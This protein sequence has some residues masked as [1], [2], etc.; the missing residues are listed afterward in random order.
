MRARWV[1]PLSGLLLVL[2]P[3]VSF[4][5]HIVGGE[6]YYECLGNNTYRITLK[7]Y[8]DCYSFGQ[9][10]AWFDNP[11][12][13][14]IYTADGNL[15]SEQQVYLTLGPDTIPPETRNPCLQAP[16]NVC[17]EE[18]VYEF[19]I[20]LPPASGG[21]DIVYVR[22]C[23]NATVQN[24]FTPNAVGATYSAHIP[25]PGVASCNSSPYFSDFPPI[26]ICANAPINF[27]HSA[28]D[29]DGDSLVYSLCTP[30]DGADS[31]TPQPYPADIL[32]PFG[33]VIWRS[34]YSAANPLDASP[35]VTLD[36]RTGF[37]TGTPTRLGQYVVGVCVREY[38]NGV[39]IG[40]TKRDFQF[41]VVQCGT[42]VQARIP[43]VDT[44]GAAATNTAGV[45]IYQCQGLFVQFINH[46]INGTYYRW[47][48]GD[49]TTNADT[50]LLFQPAYTYPDS[51][52]YIVRL[53]VNPG[54]FCADTTAVIVKIYPTFQADFDF[55]AGCA[56]LPVTFSD[57]SITTYGTIN[58]WSWNFGDG[59]ASTTQHP[60]HL[61][62]QDG[63]FAVTLFAT[64]TKGCS[65]SQ[66]KTV[67]VH[68]MPQGDFSFTPVCINTPVTFTDL[69]TISSGT[70]SSRSWLFNNNP[71][72]SSATFTQTFTNLMTFDL[73]LISSSAFGCTD[74][75]TK[76]ITVH[77]LPVAVARE[78]TS[79]CVGESV[80]L[81]ASGG[82]A[83][84]WQPA[85]GLSSATVANPLATP[86]IST[87]Y[88]VTVTDTN[89]CVDK[90][91]VNIT[92]N[93]L[94]E[95]YAGEDTYICEGSMLQLNGSGGISFLWSPGNLVS[96]S[97]LPNPTT[98]P[99]DTT[100]FVLTTYNI[101]G[102][103]NYDSL[104]IA[105]QHPI[106]LSVSPA[107]D[108]C[109]GNSV[110][111]SAAGGLYYTW[112]PAGGL[113]GIHSSDYT[114]T[115]EVSTR[116]SV[117]VSNDC[118]SDTGYVD[119]TVRPLPDVD[120]GKDTS[121]VRD[122]FVTLSGRA[123]GITHFWTPPEGLENPNSLTTLASPF[124]TTDYVL[125]AIS[126]YNC[127]ATDTMRV[128]VTVVNLIAIPT[129]FSPNS[130]GTNDIYR[131]VKTLNIERLFFFKIYNRWGQCIFETNDIR[132][133]WDGTVYGEPQDIGV[134]AFI[135]KAFN[136][137]GE[138]II[139]EGNVTLVR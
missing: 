45:F 42:N 50:S 71:F 37:L 75:V 72:D 104:T 35:A 21:Y 56:N 110:T 38:R 132:Q 47:D 19:T 112:S 54:Y 101:F 107:Q 103:R 139:K 40:E 100:T 9:N 41:N 29:A 128:S 77:P 87:L 63:N 61:Y 62:Q 123:T 130:D 98:S 134:Y 64:N 136:R 81:M 20:Y 68:P 96:D 53:I 24:I 79:L 6:M 82:T 59:I 4:A 86:A 58:S 65:D 114:I 119:V 22:C 91:S 51:G 49:P 116:Y 66:T 28:V 12:Y 25:D 120:A 83:Y 57:R 111:L 67:T 32:L 17:V 33:N 11:A 135:I 5:A 48:F 88:I 34:P 125:H 27:D 69:T 138:I 2:L 118:F 70:I 97:T 8:R 60:N 39:L 102:C 84:Q 90:D 44:A 76:T 13:I 113:P 52:V 115:T 26:V 133:G 10:V 80:R 137:D 121:L 78:D 31:L 124:N 3:M 36:A 126:A 94:P 95:T 73:T 89:Q 109:E 43:V 122:E 127:E 7:I 129:A 117:T 108:L 92:V 15:F 55:V 30:Y 131:I 23:R 46:S 74:T 85:T 16:A 93:P 14:G 1:F 106:T 18:G 99:P 105:V